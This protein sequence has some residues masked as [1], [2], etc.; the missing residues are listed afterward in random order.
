MVFA[1]TKPFIFLERYLSSDES[2]WYQSPNL[3]HIIYDN[4]V[5]QH[6]KN[7]RRDRL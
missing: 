2:L 6:S 4:V 3:L 7:L 5:Q 1:K